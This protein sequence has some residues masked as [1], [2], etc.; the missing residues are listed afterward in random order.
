MIVENTFWTN[1]DK[2]GP[3]PVNCPELGRCWLWKG[4]LNNEGYG[5]YF[6]NGKYYRA[7]RL[8]FYLTYG[9]YPNPQGLHHCDNPA[10][11]NPLHVYEGG[12]IENTKDKENRHRGNHPKGENHGAA[13][14]TREQ[15][16]DIRRLGKS[17]QSP[18]TLAELYKVSISHIRNIIAD[19]KW[20]GE[21][22]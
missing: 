10:C 4:N 20:Q 14:L 21:T 18:A 16:L 9:H 5:R 2:A 19:R 6:V 17:S 15:V 1:V 22:L 3:L 13:K 8:S 12:D 11:C 7:H